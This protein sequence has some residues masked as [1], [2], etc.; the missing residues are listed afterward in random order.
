MRIAP[1]DLPLPILIYPNEEEGGWTA[2]S[3]EMDIR[4][5][6]DTPEEALD[7]LSD[8]V[9]VQISFAVFKDD[10]SLIW[11]RADQIWFDRFAE[12]FA[13]QQWERLVMSQDVVTES[14][15]I[16]LSMVPGDTASGMPMPAPHVI[17]E[18]KRQFQVAHA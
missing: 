10:P 5:Y 12:A 15:E 17:A 3:L 18:I 6:G 16:T 4:A 11:K 8:L 1:P 2:L 7:E 14:G 9:H 13:R